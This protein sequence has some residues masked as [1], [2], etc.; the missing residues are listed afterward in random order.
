MQWKLLF[1]GAEGLNLRGFARISFFFGGGT[2]KKGLCFTGF[3]VGILEKE[4][5]QKL[6]QEIETECI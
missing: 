2:R 5:G 3:R 1:Q 4:T 6:E